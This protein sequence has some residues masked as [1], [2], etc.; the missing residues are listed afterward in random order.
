VTTR[1]APRTPTRRRSPAA[2]DSARVANRQWAASSTLL[3]PIF[4]RHLALSVS[5]RVCFRPPFRPP[6]R[7]SN[8][9][10][11]S[12]RKFFSA[13]G[14]HSAVANSGYLSRFFSNRCEMRRT[15]QNAHSGRFAPVDA[16]VRRTRYAHAVLS[17]W[18][19]FET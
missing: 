10:D 16:I 8:R 9:L 1:A 19:S 18:L 6:F 5:G 4:S 15:A 11:A 13:T 17:G 14:S 3:S 7:L 12:D 2:I